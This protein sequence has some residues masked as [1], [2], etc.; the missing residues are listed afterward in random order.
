MPTGPKSHARTVR[1]HALPC[2]ELL[3]AHKLIVAGDFITA[4]VTTSGAGDAHRHG[5]RAPR[6]K[7]REFAGRILRTC[8]VEFRPEQL[9]EAVA[10]E[11][12][13]QQLCEGIESAGASERLTS[14]SLLAS[15]LRDL[16]Q[17]RVARLQMLASQPSQNLTAAAASGAPLLRPNGNL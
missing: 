4:D 12:A 7:W 14:C 16:L 6:A 17:A 10:L 9:T 3:A 11:Q 1:D 13:A 15:S 5:I 2:C 8:D